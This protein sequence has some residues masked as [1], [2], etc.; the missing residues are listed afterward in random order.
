MQAK[1]SF[2]KAVA[3][4]GGWTVVSRVLGFVRDVV[5]ARILGA[6]P[7]ADA[8]FIAFRLPNFFR[9]LF[10]EGAFNS[11]FVPLFTEQLAEKGRAEARE[12]AEQ[13]LA[14]LG[15]VLLLLAVLGEVF[16]VLVVAA[17]AIGFHDDVR[18]D[19]AVNF[20]RITFP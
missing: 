11:A 9:Q 2:T 6:G 4:V 20:S 19:L 12:F 13:A 16:I 10:G 17:M 5:I 15:S 7:I 8:F 18:F 1:S 3:T 14:L